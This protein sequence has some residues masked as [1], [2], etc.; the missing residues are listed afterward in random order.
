[1]DDQNKIDEF[2]GK[3]KIPLVLA[4]VGVVLLIGG[5]VSSGVISKTFVKSTKYPANSQ[6]NAALAPMI[7]KVDVAGAIERPGVYLLNSESRVEDAI[8]AAGG[9]TQ[10]AD[11]QY[12][13]QSLNLAQRLSDGVKVYIPY[14]GDPAS[15]SGGSVGSVA[16]TASQNNIVNINNAG[17]DEL[18]KLPGVGPV[19]AQKIIDNRP[20]SGIEELLTKKAVSRSVYEKIKSLVST[21]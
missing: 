18:D 10:E 21:Y 2:I 6:K 9:V 1:M 14:Q 16:G 3:Y 11:S 4:L 8:K 15:V 5:I 7:I 19:T 12:L 13:S 20:Y 17:S